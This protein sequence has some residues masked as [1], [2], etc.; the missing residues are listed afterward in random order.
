MVTARIPHPPWCDLRHCDGAD[1]N[2]PVS[3]DGMH[4]STPLPQ[5]IPLATG[6]VLALRLQLVQPITGWSTQVALA[7]WDTRGGQHTPIPV[8]AL[9]A[10]I[11]DTVPLLELARLADTPEVRR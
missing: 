2:V 3:D 4:R 1:P 10:A 11:A 8:P 9:F 7:I 6:A 5:R